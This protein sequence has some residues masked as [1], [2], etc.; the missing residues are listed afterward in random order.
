MLYGDT[1]DGQKTAVQAGREYKVADQ[2]T[3]AIQMFDRALNLS[4][5]R[6]RHPAL[7]EKTAVCV[8]AGMRDEALQTIRRAMI[9]FPG[10]Q[11]VVDVMDFKGQVEHL[12][13]AQVE[14]LKTREREAAG[15]LAEAEGRLPFKKNVDMSKE[16]QAGLALARRI[17]TDYADTS[18]AFAALAVE[19]EALHLL[20]QFDAAYEAYS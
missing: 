12:S 14:S 9:E 3:K 17:E 16:R 7:Y 6:G 20:G 19:G 8:S 1:T 15:L 4:G 2:P 5:P 13:P 10:S 18:A 11:T